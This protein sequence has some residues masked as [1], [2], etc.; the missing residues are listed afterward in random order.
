MSSYSLPER[1][2]LPMLFKRTSHRS[3][4]WLPIPLEPCSPPLLT[5]EL[6]SVFGVSLGR[7]NY[8]NCDGERG[9]RAYIQLLS[10]QCPPCWRS[11]LL[12]ILFI[13]SSLEAPR[14][15]VSPARQ[16]RSVLVGQWIAEVETDRVQREASRLTLTIR[17]RTVSGKLDFCGS[18]TQGLIAARARQ[19]LRRTT[20]HL[21]RN[22]TSS[23]GGYLPNTLTEMWE[24]AR[25]FAWLK[26]QTS[27]ARC[28]VALSGTM[29]Q[30]MVISSEGYFYSYNIDL[31][32]GG[33]CPLNQQYRYVTAALLPLMT[34]LIVY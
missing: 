26:L 32:N 18:V 29:P 27:G 25:D 31:E 2:P 16:G 21:T 30:V 22:V 15:A 8:T 13:Y 11:R 20:A 17:K 1:R 28:I 4:S 6:S 5:K 10:M 24:P 12:T 23:V 34:L 14:R 3:P 19:T 9:R 7:R 33:E